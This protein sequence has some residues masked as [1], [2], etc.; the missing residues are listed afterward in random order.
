[1]GDGTLS[2]DNDIEPNR[3]VRDLQPRNG[4]VEW[5]IG[6]QIVSDIARRPSVPTSA[7]CAYH[8]QP[9]SD[10]PMTL[11]RKTSARKNHSACLFI[12]DGERAVKGDSIAFPQDVLTSVS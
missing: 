9:S 1:M 3:Q 6:R 12:G 2:D 7:L 11:V 5:H 10:F 4:T 8:G